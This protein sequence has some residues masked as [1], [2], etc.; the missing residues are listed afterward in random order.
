MRHLNTTQLSKY[1]TGQT[2][3]F[4]AA[5]RKRFEETID[6]EKLTQ[7]ELI[8][9]NMLFA[10]SVAKQYFKYLTTYNYYSIDESDLIQ[11]AY[12]GLC[13]AAPLFDE[14]KGNKFISFAVIY[15]RNRIILALNEYKFVR[16]PVNVN[17]DLGKIHKFVNQFISKY[18]LFPSYD[19][20]LVGTGC[21]ELSV[22]SYFNRIEMTSYDK[23]LFSDVTFEDSYDGGIKNN[24]EEIEYNKHK[25]SSILAM[26]PKDESTVFK[27]R[28][29]ESKSLS[30]IAFAIN[31]TEDTVK[32]KLLDGMKRIKKLLN[33]KV[34]T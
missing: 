22:K 9:K 25:V 14:S 26:L 6:P 33:I 23:P 12:L 2:Y 11:E 34:G 24:V 19:D 13:E 31:R 1:T 8:E 7:N 30:E 15:I 27:L 32:R 3:E 10:I 21:Q 4:I 17:T 16:V 28:F 29:I 20:V 5:A 18:E